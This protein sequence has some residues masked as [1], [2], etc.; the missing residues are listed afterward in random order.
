M[1]TTSA[2]HVPSPRATGAAQLW[3][4]FDC[5]GRTFGFP[6]ERVREIVLPG[7]ITRLPG[8]GPEVAGLIGLRGRI[9]TVFDVGARLGLRPAAAQ[10][11]HRLLLLEC[12]EQLVA[13]AVERV[14]AIQE[15]PVR[16]LG[17]LRAVLK[18]IDVEREAVLGVGKVDGEPFVALDS[19]RLLGSLLL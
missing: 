12:G 19:D 11:D 7:P 13:G 1:A 15:V 18:G 9:V 14:A 4:V 5:D 2:T 17:R 16:P 3:A 6:L 10:G 8:C